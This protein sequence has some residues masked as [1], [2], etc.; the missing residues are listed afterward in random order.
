M[1]ERALLLKV[2]GE[3][4]RGR[5]RRAG[6]NEKCREARKNKATFLDRGAKVKTAAKGIY[7]IEWRKSCAILSKGR[8]RKGL[9]GKR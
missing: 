9:G 5:T 2:T 4:S 1:D 8:V 6:S 3:L 7:K